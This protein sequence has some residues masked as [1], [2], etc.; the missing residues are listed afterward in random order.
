MDK[1]YTQIIEKILYA[2]LFLIV[3]PAS[4]ILWARATAGCVPLLVVGSFQIGA[5]L[6]IC[7]AVI[8]IT[9]MVALSAYG[10]G[11]P[12]SPFP[13]SRYVTEGIYGFMPHPIYS[14]FSLLCV[15]TAMAAKSASGL[16]LV[17]PIVI[18]ACT[19]WVLGF[20]RDSLR[21]RFGSLITKAFIHLPEDKASAPTLADRLSVYVLVFF[22]WLILYQ[23]VRIFGIPP[24]AHIAFFSFEIDLPVYEWTEVFYISTYPYVLLAPL[25][26]K[27]MHD[28]RKFSISG[29]IATGIIIPLFL[30]VP[31]IAPPR[32]FTPNSFL[33]NLLAL[34][35]V[36]DT[37]AA[38]FPSFHV[39]WAL[40]AA[41]VYAE[42]KPS[43]RIFWWGWA[44]IIV[45][46]CITT[47]MHALV[48]VL[49]GAVAFL[50]VL[51]IDKIWEKILLIVEGIANSWREWRFGSVRLIN[52]GI[53]AG[54]G[55][56][57]GLSLVGVL[58]GQGYIAPSLIVA[59]SSVIISALW[60]Q[61]IEGSAVLLRP[62][63]YYGGVFGVVLGSLIA[64]WVGADVWLLL[65]AFSVA[66][67]WI[68][69][70][71]RLR[72]LVQGC[73][74]G[75]EASREIGIRYVHPRS[76]VTQIA[77]LTD[78][79][80]HPTPLYS[81][82]W[83]IVV[84]L[85]MARLWSLHSHPPFIGGL[86]LILTGLGRFVEENYRGEPQTRI[87]WGLR[88]YQ[89][90]AVGAVIAGAIVTTV[91]YRVEVPSPMFNWKSVMVAACV[92]ILTFFAFGA[93]FPNSKKR[94]SRLV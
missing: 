31:L 21:R 20:E 75:R 40:L 53:Y 65:A 2:F 52:H 14:G 37:P 30:I 9:G 76:R 36:F 25:A 64:K 44:F 94:F 77:G 62:Y 43:W 70:F 60:A 35:R 81:I 82:L 56:F 69:A 41:S 1:T 29:L 13:P 61:F 38:A 80:I 93:D 19:A 24:D 23:A 49:A 12:M 32:P 50:F 27:K 74:H 51:H 48:D 90:L 89:W 58:L 55:S 54:I 66:G 45:V 22:P 33:G 17:S 79:P 47:G 85:I 16:W 7:G 92:G 59:L 3:L 8:M 42:A 87:L 15:G 86:Y 91:H 5:V 10:N 28:L 26:A 39:F 67:P 6:A 71:G 34:E 88:L 83:N 78:I 63:G 84:G 73:C 11:L 57:L 68:Q 18:L 4:L 46:S 72:C